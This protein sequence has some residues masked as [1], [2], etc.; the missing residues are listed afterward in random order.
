MFNRFVHTIAPAVRYTFSCGKGGRRQDP[1]RADELSSR[2]AGA[3]HLH[4]VQTP[5]AEGVHHLPKANIT[6]TPRVASPCPR[7]HIRNFAFIRSAV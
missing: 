5:H 2:A 3:H 4:E 7:E 6:A 1:A